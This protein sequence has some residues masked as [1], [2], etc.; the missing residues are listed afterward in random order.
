MVARLPETVSLLAARAA[1]LE[2]VDNAEARVMVA[3]SESSI[4]ET[5]GRAGGLVLSELLIR[6]VE[7]FK[8]LA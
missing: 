7:F 5:S 6:F 8:G 3:L 4:L 2:V 1:E